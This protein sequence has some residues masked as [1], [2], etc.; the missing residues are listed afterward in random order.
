MKSL[1]WQEKSASIELSINY[2]SPK[3]K[4]KKVDLISFDFA[5]FLNSKK[6]GDKYSAY[7]KEDNLVRESKEL[8]LKIW[9]SIEIGIASS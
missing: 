9:F 8:G 6:V 1:N 5:Q 4:F 2:S 3:D 7:F